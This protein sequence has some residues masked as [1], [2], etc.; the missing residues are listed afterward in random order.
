M[1]SDADVGDDPR[2]HGGWSPGIHIRSIRSS[3][4]YPLPNTSAM[5]SF[6]EGARAF[7]RRSMMNIT[8]HQRNTS[9]KDLSG[10]S[11]LPHESRTFGPD[12]T[13]YTVTLNQDGSVTKSSM[14]GVFVSPESDRQ[15]QQQQ[16]QQQRPEYAFELRSAPRQRWTLLVYKPGFPYQ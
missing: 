9:P 11:I 4:F 13:A 2:P 14:P 12:V 5:G 15:Q 1:S 6:G 10:I 7:L 8:S 16:Q 3:R